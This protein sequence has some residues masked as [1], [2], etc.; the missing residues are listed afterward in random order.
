M[1]GS[2]KQEAPTEEKKDPTQDTSLFR[3]GRKPLEREAELHVLIWT[4]AA[5]IAADVVVSY[6]GITFF[7]ATEGNPLYYMLGMGGFMMLKIIV[8]AVVL[9][10]MWRH[11]ETAMSYWSVGGM[12]G[13]YWAVLVNNL[14]VMMSA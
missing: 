8:S 10:L 5:L 12:C 3:T 4:L 11:R 7:G 9:W 13:F 1:S 14:V 6:V 2:S